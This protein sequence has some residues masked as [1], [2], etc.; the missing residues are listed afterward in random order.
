MGE[1]FFEKQH[2]REPEKPRKPFKPVIKEGTGKT[3]IGF[4]KKEIR[5]TS[6]DE[7]IRFLKETL[8]KGPEIMQG[9]VITE[10]AGLFYPLGEVQNGHSVTKG[11]KIYYLKGS[12]VEGVICAPADGIISGLPEKGAQVKEKGELFTI[13]PTSEK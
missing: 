3:P 4:I 11:Q 10:H 12:G 13:T 2:I 5:K 8:K 1:N 9:P 7:D 6:L